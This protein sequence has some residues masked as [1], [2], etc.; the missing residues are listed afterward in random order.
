[1]T[2]GLFIPLGEGRR[3]LHSAIFPLSDA[4]VFSRRPGR[5]RLFPYYHL[6]LLIFAVRIR[7]W[8]ATLRYGAEAEVGAGASAIDENGQ[9]GDPDIVEVGIFFD[10][11]PNGRGKG[12]HNRGRVDQD[13]EGVGV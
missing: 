12:R 11:F 9:F 2:E 6:I 8:L 4:A 1:M 7:R 3:L 10:E 5:I 13:V